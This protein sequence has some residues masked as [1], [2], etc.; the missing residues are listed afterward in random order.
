MKNSIKI[1]LYIIGVLFLMLGSMSFIDPTGEMFVMKFGVIP[2]PSHPAHGLNSLRG[3]FGGVIFSFGVMI[4][5]GYKTL[6]RTWFDA[7]ALSM[8][9]LV[10]GRVIA[11]FV[12]GFDPLS[13]G[14]FI[15]EAITIPVLLYAGKSLAEGS[16]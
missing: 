16:K 13:L 9:L 10:L 5:L 1:Y 8:G 2:D 12:D 15:G 7:V 11:L 6:N 3:V 14:G 4:I